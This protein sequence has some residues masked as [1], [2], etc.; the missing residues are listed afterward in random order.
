MLSNSVRWPFVESPKGKECWDLK[1]SSKPST[2]SLCIPQFRIPHSLSLRS[3]LRPGAR[4]RSMGKLCT[5]GLQTLT[6]RR[7]CSPTP[8]CLLTEFVATSGFGQD[9]SGCGP[10][11]PCLG[12]EAHAESI[13][14]AFTSVTAR[15][16]VTD[17]HVFSG[18]HI[19][20]PRIQRKLCPPV[21]KAWPCRPDPCALFGQNLASNRPLRRPPKPFRSTT[22]SHCLSV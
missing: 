17:T 7:R 20:V 15:R 19:D 10:G 13:V 2:V 21:A 22:Q 3:R 6:R 8:A 14:L 5:S 16:T 18:H 12:S 11:I 4:I 1:P 9:S